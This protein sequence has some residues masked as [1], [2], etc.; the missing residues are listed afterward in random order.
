MKVEE[1]LKKVLEIPDLVLKKHEHSNKSIIDKITQTF[2]D[3]WNSAYNHIS[4]NISH[5]TGAERS[6]W[7]DAD[8]KKHTH[9]NKTI[10]D[11]INQS[12]LDNWSD[13]YTKNEI[14]N[15]ISQ[16]IT[17][18][19]WKES[20][21]TFSDI[22]KTY[23]TADDGWTVNVKDNNITYRYD[24][25]KWI[26]ISSNSIPLA[27]NTLDGRM[28]KNDKCKLDGI[29]INANNYV[30]PSTHL[31]SIIIEDSSHRFMTDTERNNLNDCNNKKHTHD[32][33]SIIDKI[34]Q[35]LLDNW[36]S[37]FSHVSD[38]VKHITSNERNLWNTVSNKVD[39]VSGKQLSTNDYTNDE[40][41]KLSGIAT[42]ANNYMHPANHSAD[43][44]VENPNKRFT[45]DT[46]KSKWNMVDNK[47]DK[48]GG[49]IAGALKILGTAESKSFIT[50][51]IQGSDGNGDIG[52]LYL[53][54]NNNNPVYVNGTNKIYHEGNKPNKNDIGLNNVDN[55]N[56]LDK[57]ISKATQNALNG[58]ANSNHTHTKN[59]ITDIPTKLSQFVNDKN[60]ITQA[61]V[62]TSQNHVHSNK[63]TLDK[64]TQ[65]LID[66]WNTVSNKSDKSYVDGELSKKANNHNHPYRQ[67]TWVPSWGDI[68]GKPST[69]TPS[70]HT[71][72]DRYYT[73]SEIDTKMN[74][75][76]NSSHMHSIDRKSANDLPSTWPI[77]VYMSEVYNN[78]FPCSYGNCLTMKS[79]SSAIT[80]I[81]MEWS[82]SDA[83]IGSMWIRNKRDTGIDKF[84]E[85]RKFSFTD[86]NHNYNDLSGKPDIPSKLSQLLKDIN[87]DDR[88]YTES[89]MNIKL[90]EKSNIN[91]NHNYAGSLSAGG[92]A[93]TAVKLAT[94]RNIN[95]VAFDGSSNI[96]VTDSTK[97]P[98]AGGT[99]TGRTSFSQGISV[100]NINGGAGTSGYMYLAQIKITGNYQ[101]QPI[102]FNIHQRER[103]GTIIIKFNSQNSSD[104]TLAY[105]N[106][107]GSSGFNA[108]ICKSATSTW[109]L[110]LQKS[111]G[112]DSIDIVGFSKG[113]YMSSTLITWQ[114]STVT[115]L[116]GGYTTASVGYLDIAVT[117]ANQDGNGNDIT[118]TY[119]KKGMTWNDLE[120]I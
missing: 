92:P 73:E 79:S 91:H 57:P 112:Y 116:P 37:A 76:A 7:N 4:D 44:I 42:N 60:F 96:T 17:D 14:D 80:Q 115:S 31:A 53:N 118:S 8:S 113:D 101:N 34:T 114:S 86:H 2:L 5:I 46:E 72:D 97:L 40:K 51:G 19:D 110:Y 27:T 47:L 82:G 32:N 11:K 55:T 106:K 25:S 61:D 38:A 48:N 33:K 63:S 26:D 43:I 22:A 90:D 18:L 120:G 81:C 41:N 77:G 111:E 9:E 1:I 67:D 59:E 16:V 45:T 64:I 68:T 24:G 107:I 75:K 10:L 71:H 65:V 30:H 28:S 104:P 103:F 89:E 36:N 99:V 3:N 102:V 69:Y 85:W 78:G 12:S 29:D 105:I 95:G 6:N 54:Y 70:G 74:S 100:K 66:S 109:D 87:F 52:E 93:N 117:K 58:K 20:V 62:D 88:Y 23:P 94:A 35:A 50:R 108:Y 56:D 49:N 83:T 98:I 84:S 119:V 15:K 13:K 21:N 39:K